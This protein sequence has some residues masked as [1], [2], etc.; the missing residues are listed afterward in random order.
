MND[1]ASFSECL[2][3][4]ADSARSK[5]LS[6]WVGAGIS[7]PV[8]P[9]GNGL[10]FY[11]LEK[12]CD[13]PELRGLHERR[14]QQQK[15]IGLRI[16][17]WPLEAFVE[18]IYRN[19]ASIVST[20]CKVFQVGSPKKNHL[21]IA[22]LVGKGIMRSVLTTNFDLLIE[23]ALEA[24]GWRKL[25]DYLVYHSED[26]F[27]ALYGDALPAIIKLHGS[28]DD[29]NS[30]RVTLSQVSRRTLTESRGR[31]LTRFLSDEGDVLVLG[32]SAR[33]DFDIN[34]LLSRVKPRKRIFYVRHDIDRR[35]V[36]VLPSAFRN[37]EGCTVQCNTDLVMDSL[38]REFGLE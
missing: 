15:D 2:A 13:N 14:L 9:L 34:P 18:S 22:K 5:A 6:L 27:S 32:Y 37:F 28:A 25:D 35:E 12:L 17:E 7:W 20:L 36:G 30:I 38:A 19:E 10:K 26:Q 33:D 8:F 23:R 16:E 31:V 4:I 21:I 24:Q 1:A 3:Q 11:I 29:E